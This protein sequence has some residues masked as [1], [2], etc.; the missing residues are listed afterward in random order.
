[1][2]GIQV[3]T[4]TDRSGTTDTTSQIIMTAEN[5]KIRAGWFFQNISDTV[6][7][8][9]FTSAASAAGTSIQLPAGQS[10]SSG[11]FCTQE[12]IS[13]YCAVIGKKFVAKEFHQS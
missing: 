2:I 8:I 6:M 1:M 12:R 11:S 5:Y 3:G 4:Y 13:L 10:I 7:Y 9:N